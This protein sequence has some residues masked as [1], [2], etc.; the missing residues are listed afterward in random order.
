MSTLGYHFPEFT[1]GACSFVHRVMP[2]L[3]GAIPGSAQPRAAEPGGL[4]T[5]ITP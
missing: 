5:A 2:S 4:L 1:I 3:G